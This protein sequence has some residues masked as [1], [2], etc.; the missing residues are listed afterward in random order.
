[1]NEAA[2]SPQVTT[3]GLEFADRLERLLQLPLDHADHVAPWYVARGE[4]TDWIDAHFSELPFGV[5]HHLYHYF[6]DADIRAKEPGY[7]TDQEDAVRLVIRQ[8]R[9]EP[10]PEPKRAWWHFW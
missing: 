9:G 6:D 7:R 1:M 10:L 3:R 5:P 4:L 2:T 8:L